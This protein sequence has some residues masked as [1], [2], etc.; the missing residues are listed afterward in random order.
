MW[1]TFSEGGSLPLLIVHLH[2]RFPLKPAGEKYPFQQREASLS[3][4]LK[5]LSSGPSEPRALK[6]TA[7]EN[8]KQMG[9]GR[10]TG[11]QI[12][13]VSGNM[14][15]SLRNPS[16][17]ILS[18]TQM[19]MGQNEMT[20]NWVDIFDPQPN[21]PF[22]RSC[23]EARPHAPRVSRASRLYGPRLHVGYFQE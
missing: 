22:K 9:M 2:D 14:D 16:C 13:L 12:N 19:G 15:Q 1:T 23:H 7:G 4:S 5:H 17:L 20:R 3:T 18:H 8:G 6:R 21:Q 11:T 10:K